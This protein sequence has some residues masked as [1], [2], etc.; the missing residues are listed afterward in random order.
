ME[1]FVSK[2]KCEFYKKFS[3]EVFIYNSS[4]KD[5]THLKQQ[6]QNYDASWM[7]LQEMLDYT[8]CDFT[9]Y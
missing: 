7:N 4:W 1:I 5:D 9:Y 6:L 8:K 2:L 3:M